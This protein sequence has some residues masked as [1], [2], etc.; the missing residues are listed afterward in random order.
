LVAEAKVM[1]FVKMGLSNN[2]KSKVIAEIFKNYSK[3]PIANL[4]NALQQISV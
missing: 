3:T 1:K 2:M 4:E